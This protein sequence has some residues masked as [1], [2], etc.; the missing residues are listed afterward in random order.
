[1]QKAEDR[2][3]AARGVTDKGALEKGRD[4]QRWMCKLSVLTVKLDFSSTGL[5]ELA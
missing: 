3:V 4:A 1:M 2:G 5:V